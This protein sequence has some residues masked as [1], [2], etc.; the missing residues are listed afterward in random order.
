M[1]V[2]KEGKRQKACENQDNCEC[3]VNKRAYA[4]FVKG[5]FHGVKV[6]RGGTKSFSFASCY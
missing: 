1:A 3:L 4:L 2:E 5:H 6:G